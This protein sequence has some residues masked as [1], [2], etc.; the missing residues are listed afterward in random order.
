[1]CWINPKTISWSAR[2]QSLYFHLPMSSNTYS[3]ASPEQEIQPV[4]WG[5]FIK[6]QHFISM[7]GR[8]AAHETREF[9]HAMGD[10]TVLAL[11]CYT[12]LFIPLLSA[13]LPSRRANMEDIDRPCTSMNDSSLALVYYV[14]INALFCIEKNDGV[15]LLACPKFIS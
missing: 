6:Y 1:M 11:W 9:L 2:N 14:P 13:S 3:I 8:V 10:E 15:K 7:K 12:K 4:C 5:C